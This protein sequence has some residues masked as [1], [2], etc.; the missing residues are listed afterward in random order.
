M[1][2]PRETSA[3]L[4]SPRLRIAPSLL[5]ADFARLAD[6]LQRIEAAG[7]DLLHLDVMDGHYVP[8]ISFGIPVIEKIRGACGLYFDTHLMIMEPDRY[9]E[10]FV[11]AGADGITFHT[12]VVRHPRPLIE[13]LRRLG[14]AVGVSL[15]PRT[16]VTALDDCLADVNLVNVM[17]VE[18][19]FG[20]Q[21]FMPDMLEKVRALRPRLRP[22]QRL[23]VDGGLNRDNIAQAVAA[24]ADTIVAGTAVFRAADPAAALDELRRLG[25][26]AGRRAE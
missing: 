10:S 18:P 2:S 7:A 19:G 3:S 11:K 26:S 12:E 13:R 6:E 15:N 20:G 4:G 9:A 8:N 16:P 17:T 23:E 24:G 1:T 25:G 22:D 14:V 21:A 5:A